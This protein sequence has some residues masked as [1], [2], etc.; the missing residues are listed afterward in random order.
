MRRLAFIKAV[1]T[2]SVAQ[3]YQPEPLSSMSIL[4]FHD[5]VEL[6]LQLSSEHIGVSKKER[7]AFLEYWRV[8][9]DKMKEGELLQ[10]EAMSR[11]NKSRVALKHHGTLPSKLDL[12]AFRASATNFFEDN[13]QLIF[14]IPFSKISLIELVQPEEV[15]NFLAKASNFL[16]D[17]NIQKALREI[18]LSFASLILSFESNKE[19]S[20][21]SS[22]FQHGKDL[23]HIDVDLPESLQSGD[24]DLR[25]YMYQITETVKALQDATKILTIGI[26]YRKYGRFK[27]FMPNVAMFPDKYYVTGTRGS[28]AC[29]IE[30]ARFCLN[31]VI[32]TAI[33][34]NENNYVAPKFE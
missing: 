19:A 14:N 13:T 12:E 24:N 30:D 4:S 29:T 31:F 21:F 23:S 2:S 26:D 9:S 8:I 27:Y 6:F 32:E 22:P 18:A 3:S 16:E 11:L 7:L 15:K 17:N 10:K 25:D 5:S 28:E 33:L 34:L 1:Y 20:F